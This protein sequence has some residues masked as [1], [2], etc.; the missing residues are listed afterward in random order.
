[1]SY[2]W[3][4]SYSRDMSYSWDMNQKEELGA[5][6]ERRKGTKV[7]GKGGLEKLEKKKGWRRLVVPLVGHSSTASLYCSEQLRLLLKSELRSYYSTPLLSPLSFHRGCCVPPPSDTATW[8]ELSP[9]NNLIGAAAGA[10]VVLLSPTLPPLLLLYPT[11]LH[12]C[13]TT[14]FVED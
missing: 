11:C 10:I 7:M 1:M 8:S 2:S 9:H 13:Q 5:S 6:K 14:F 4:M 12:C 3:D